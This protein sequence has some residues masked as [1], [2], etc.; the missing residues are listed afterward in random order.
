MAVAQVALPWN[1]DPFAALFMV[2]TRTIS[3]HSTLPFSGLR[4]L[5][6]ALKHVH[7]LAASSSDWF[8]AVGDFWMITLP[9][10]PSRRAL[11]SIDH[12]V[13]LHLDTL[14]PSQPYLPPED[15]KKLEWSD[16]PEKVHIASARLDLYDSLAKAGHEGAKGPTPDPELLRM[17]LW[18]EN[19]GVCRRAFNWCLDLVHICQS[20]TPGNANSTGMFIPEAMGHEWVV[21]FIQVLCQ[22]ENRMRFGSWDLLTSRLFPKWAMLPSSWCHDFASA[23]LV[24]AVQSPDAAGLLA[25]QFLAD[26]HVYVSRDRQQLFL[27]FLATL[28]AV[29]KSSLTWDAIIPLENWLARLPERLENQDAHAQMEDILATR[30]QQLQEENLCLFVELPMAREWLEEILEFFAEL[31]MADEW[32]EE[33]LRLFAEL[34]MAS[35]WMDE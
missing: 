23:L 34:P 19:H 26:H 8:K 5:E 9:G 15:V 35:E 16:T 18:S 3:G 25:Y 29:V 33:I 2:I 13:L 31:P 1:P 11:M 12:W 14:F 17:F 21:H 6:I 4:V 20:G 22:G 10:H 27:P 24:T 32:M 30:R 28:L 7:K